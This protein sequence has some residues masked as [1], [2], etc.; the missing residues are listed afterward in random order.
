MASKAFSPPD[1]LEGSEDENEFS[2]K[3]F[4]KLMSN[5]SD[6]DRDTTSRAD[7]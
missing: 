1:D 5:M 6:V 7:E 2:L 3:W 4:V